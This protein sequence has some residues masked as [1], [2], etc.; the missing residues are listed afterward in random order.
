M[1]N[2]CD[3]LYCCD[4]GLRCKFQGIT[5]QVLDTKMERFFWGSLLFISYT[6][7]GY[8]FWLFLRKLFLANP[9][10]VYEAGK[11][12]PGVSVIIAA[13][14]EEK[15]ICQ[16]IENISRQNYPQS[17]IQIIVVSDGST[18][19]T[20]SELSKLNCPNLE[21]IM[22]LENQGKAVAINSGVAAA[23]GEITIFSDVRQNFDPFAIAY[24]VDAF[25]DHNI[26]CVSGELIL[27]KNGESSIHT[28]IG[29]YWKYEKWIRKMES[30]T[31]SVVGATGAIYAI[32]KK[33]YRSLPQGTLLDD[34]LT[35]MNIV[36]QGYRCV[37][38]SNAIAYDYVSKDLTQEWKR[39]VRTLT[40][41][42][43]LLNLSPSLLVPWKN[44][45]W[46]RFLAHKIYR[47][48]VPFALVVLFLTSPLS[49]GI[50]Y[51]I[52]TLLQIILYLLALFGKFF[53]VARK[54]KL[55]NLIY[56]FMV[57][58]AAAVTGLWKL[59]SGRCN[60]VWQSNL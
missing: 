34:V 25:S 53:P 32:R 39:K 45:I 37:F 49:Q 30:A 10:P 51:K 41:N 43:Q 38:N 2:L 23:K 15:N 1:R 60:D 20:V 56:F 14:N 7:I 33:L 9:L 3:R 58:N 50:F 4:K 24:L 55:V 42:W 48:L 31:G 46:G 13:Y 27:L 18:D 52:A 47:L 40:G 35:P 6:Y 29:L 54:N 16:R 12:L 17:K 19:R 21:I 5:G 44:P 59:I 57:M 28:E 22:L 26:G 11:E 8:P 36:T